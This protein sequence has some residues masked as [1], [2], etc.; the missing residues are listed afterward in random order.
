MSHPMRKWSSRSED[1]RCPLALMGWRDR[2]PGSIIARPDRPTAPR[3]G[4]DR[5]TLIRPSEGPAPVSPP[6]PPPDQG[7]DAGRERF[8]LWLAIR[9]H[10][11][12]RRTLRLDQARGREGRVELSA[13]LEP[14]QGR[15][16]GPRMRARY[17]P[18]RRP[19]QRPE[20]VNA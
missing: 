18:T 9:R 16:G 12:G 3:K 19:G 14:H 6:P 15:R 11:R 17:H 4:P 2:A 1:L 13:R 5:E 7:L 20:R 10:P 8:R